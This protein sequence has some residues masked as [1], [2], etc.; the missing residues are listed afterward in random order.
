MSKVVELIGE[1]MSENVHNLETLIKTLV[2]KKKRKKNSLKE[3][4]FLKPSALCIIR[5]ILFSRRLD[6]SLINV[7]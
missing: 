7:D 6:Y 4:C 2:S 3:T 1:A 5:S